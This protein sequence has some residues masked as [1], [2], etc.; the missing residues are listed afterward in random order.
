MFGCYQQPLVICIR[1]PYQILMSTFFR[2]QVKNQKRIKIL[3][4]FCF[5]KSSRGIRSY[6][7]GSLWSFHICKYLTTVLT[8]KK[9][10][11][12]IICSIHTVNRCSETSFFLINVLARMLLCLIRGLRWIVLPHHKHQS[13]NIKTIYIIVKSP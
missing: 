4:I 7:I 2:L 8:H 10:V 11:M 13:V 12:R 3:L 5:K 1:D 6:F 9:I